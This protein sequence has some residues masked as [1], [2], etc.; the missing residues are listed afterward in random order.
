MCRFRRPERGEHARQRARNPR[1]GARKEAQARF[2]RR[3]DSVN[4]IS[5][6]VGAVR[7]Y[8]SMSGPLICSCRFRGRSG[9]ALCILGVC[10]SVG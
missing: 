7:V 1:A 9:L 5:K 4:T 10:S 3:L 8:V 6:H 2:A